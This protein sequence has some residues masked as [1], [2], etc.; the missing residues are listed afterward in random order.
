M[1]ALKLGRERRFGLPPS[2]VRRDH[3]QAFHDRPGLSK[4]RDVY[5][6]IRMR[7]RAYGHLWGFTGHG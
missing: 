4:G 3:S 1:T 2:L 5:W 6:V 7:I